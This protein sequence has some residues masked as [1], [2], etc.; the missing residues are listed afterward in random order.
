MKMVDTREYVS[1]LKELVEEGKE[2]RMLI[3]GSSMSP[4]LIHARDSIFFFSARRSVK[5][6]G[7]GI[8]SENLR[9][10]CD[11]SDLQSQAGGVLSGRRC[12]DCSGGAD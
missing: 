10:V 12:T 5:N 4:F 11:A 1:V 3:S 6:R 8:L 9:T 7:Y 2:V